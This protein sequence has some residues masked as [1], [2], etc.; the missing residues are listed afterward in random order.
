MEGGDGGA[1]LIHGGNGDEHLRAVGENA[2]EDAREG[3]EKRRGLSGADAVVFRHFLRD[4]V[5]HNDGD[6]IVRRGDIHRADEKSHAELSAAFAAEYALNA[7][8]KRVKAA[9]F[10]N[11]RT[12]RGD[13]NGD[14]GGLEHA[15]RAR[16]HAREKRGEGDGT[17]GKHD[18]GAR[19][20][21]GKQD[22]KDVDADD[23]ADEHEQIR[24]RFDELIALFLD[25][26]DIG[27]KRE[28]KNEHEG[29]DGGGKND[30]EVRAE[31]IPHRA[32]L[33]AAG[34]DG[35]IGNKG[36]V[37]PEHG[38][39]HDRTDAKRHGE[40]RRLRDGDG[41]G[42][43]QGDGA[44]RGAHGGG[45]EAADEEQNAHGEA[46]RNERKH[47]IGDALGGAS[48]DDADEDA[49]EQEDEQHGDDVFVSDAAAHDGKLFIEGQLFVLQSRREERDEKDDH[50]GHAVKA[51]GDLHDIFEG[52]A[53]PKVQNDKD[54]D[55]QKRERVSFFHGESSLFLIAYSV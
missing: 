13:E 16:S 35:G 39:A 19:E 18:D 53:E 26:T 27:T 37:V 42:G 36:K 34:G 30:G 31:F 8:E 38:A 5:C 20:N 7:V 49:R 1:E 4:G 11:E 3:I 12:Y 32:P 21:G 48:A 33:T 22:D 46:R 41:D 55:G 52:D 2:L 28:Q 54:A 25:R 15:R 44:D 9:V 50:H 45:N 17:R 40:A 24:D 10:T 51:H 23:T 47:E 6:G 29:D 14:H 43:D